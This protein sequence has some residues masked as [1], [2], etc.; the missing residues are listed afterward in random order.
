[1]ARELH[2]TTSQLL[3]VLQLHIGELRRAG[4]RDGGPLLNQLEQTLSEIRQQIR[5]LGSDSR[6]A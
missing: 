5:L 1:M 6:A 2:D 3:V 4:L